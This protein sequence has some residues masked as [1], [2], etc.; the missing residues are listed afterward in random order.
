[1]SGD[2]SSATPEEI[3]ARQLDEVLRTLRPVVQDLR[4]ELPADARVQR[5]LAELDR[6]LG[7][8][9]LAVVNVTLSGH[10]DVRRTLGE[11]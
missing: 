1:M 3:L 2:S 6:T 5:S 8:Y 7:L 11:S 10:A 9:G 4:D